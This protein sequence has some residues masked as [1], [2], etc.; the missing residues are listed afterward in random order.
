VLDMV[1]FVGLE[2]L[3]WIW[4]ALWDWR[5]RVGY[6]LLCGTGGIVLDM[7]CIVGLEELCWIW[8]ALWDWTNCVGNGQLLG[9][10]DGTL[11]TVSLLAGRLTKTQSVPRSK[12]SPS[13]LYKPVS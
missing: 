1:C 8:S 12:H 5:N 11:H 9:L 13:R 2:E 4:S 6:G 3:C 7:V 10:R